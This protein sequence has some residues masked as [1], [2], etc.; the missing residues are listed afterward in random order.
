M[1]QS[2]LDLAELTEL[3]HHL[4]ERSGQKTE[5]TR[6]IVAVIQANSCDQIVTGLG[7]ASGCGDL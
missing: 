2:N 7:G 6:R 5:T 1:E 4:P 3:G